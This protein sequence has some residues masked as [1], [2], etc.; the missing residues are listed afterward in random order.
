MLVDVMQAPITP[1]TRTMLTAGF[2]VYCVLMLIIGGIASRY[3]KDIRDFFVA[4]GRLGFWVLLFT[5]MATFMSGMGYMAVCGTCYKLGW[6]FLMETYWP[7]IGISASALVIGSR[8][9]R[10]AKKHNLITIPDYY[11]LRWGSL[12]RIGAIVPVL[13]IAVFY[14]IGQYK[15]LGIILQSLVGWPYEVAVVVATIIFMAYTFMGGLYAVAWTDYI[16]GWILLIGITILLPIVYSMAGGPE[17][18]FTALKNSDPNLVAPWSPAGPT[19][20]PVWISFLVAV[21]LGTFSL[22]HTIHRHWMARKVG[23]YKWLPLAALLWWLWGHYGSKYAGLGGRALTEMGILPNLAV[24]DPD[25]VLPNLC[26]YVLPPALAAFMVAAIAAAVM[27]TADSL[28]I[29]AANTVVR[30]IY[31]VSYTHLTLP[32]N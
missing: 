29:L 25:Y 14:V 13:A 32:T 18:A 8:I 20:W 26:L 22:P 6:G 3:I 23:Y 4:G 24:P 17:A 28:I 9:I 27:S 16:Q 7:A 30:D 10:L 15:A 2:I 1:E 19:S 5:Y 31:P 21:G 12:A 11:E